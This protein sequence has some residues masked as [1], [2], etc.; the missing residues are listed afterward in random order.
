MSRDRLRFV[1]RASVVALLIMS[2]IGCSTVAG[3]GGRLPVLPQPDVTASESYRLLPGDSIRVSVFDVPALSGD[4]RVDETGIVDLP[5]VGRVRTSGATASELASYLSTRLAEKYVKDPNVIVQVIEYRHIFV[6]G[7][8]RNP[9]GYPYT[10]SMSVL[11][12]AAVAGGFTVRSDRRDI[13][14]TRSGKRYRGTLD[15]VVLPGDSIEIGLR[16]F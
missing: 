7:E 16:Y 4:F 9:G 5:L 10:P 6:L 3:G 13:V 1:V 2:V 8:V 14:V 12:A 11:N 15:S